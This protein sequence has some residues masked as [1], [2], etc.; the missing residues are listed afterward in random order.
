LR[1]IDSIFPHQNT[2][3]E[4]YINVEKRDW[5]SWDERIPA[6]FKPQEKGLDFHRISVPT[7]D[8]ARN[9]YLIQSLLKHGSQVLLV[10]HTGVGK[11]SL[12]EGILMALDISVSSFT[13]NFSAGTT[14]D[15]T[16]Q[17]IESNFERRTK[18]KYTP[19]N[20]KKKS[21]CFVDDLNM[22]RKDT[23]GSQPPL[24]L[25]RQWIDYG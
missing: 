11:T 9:K 3:Y 6:S 25:I 5:A 16:Q 8:T 4:H 23:Y 10:G 20:A 15:S 22:P 12:I 7:I 21:I 1:D 18:S 19:K 2:I 13:L 17:L 14:S 24:E